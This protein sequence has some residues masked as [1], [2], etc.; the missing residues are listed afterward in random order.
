MSALDDP[1]SHPTEYKTRRYGQRSAPE[2]APG[3]NRGAST[4]DFDGRENSWSVSSSN[5]DCPHSEVTSAVTVPV[6]ATSTEVTVPHDVTRTGIVNP[7]HTLLEIHMA[8]T[9]RNV[10]L[11]IAPQKVTQSR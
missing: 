2:H 4:R 6:D 9:H 1:V 5:L 3:G 11:E 10:T 7:D 8:T